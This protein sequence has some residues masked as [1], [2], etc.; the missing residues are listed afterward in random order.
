M[1]VQQV[2]VH[3]TFYVIISLHAC[4]MSCL[5][6][7]KLTRNFEINIQ[8]THIKI[9]GCLFSYVSSFYFTLCA[10]CIVYIA[11]IYAWTYSDNYNSQHPLPACPETIIANIVAIFEKIKWL[12]F[13][14]SISNKYDCYHF[15]RSQ[16]PIF[17][18]IR[19]AIDSGNSNC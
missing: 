15:R 11:F 3:H 17:R 4:M 10:L 16:L 13:V 19:I 7:G 9:C 14:A 1:L 6:D 5:R 2:H 12:A 8:S 18:E